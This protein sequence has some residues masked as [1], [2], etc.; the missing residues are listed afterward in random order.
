MIHARR[1][2]EAR[3][4]EAHGGGCDNSGA[5]GHLEAT[6][7]ALMNYL[8]LNGPGPRRGKD[9]VW[10]RLV[11]ERFRPQL[12]GIVEAINE[13]PSQNGNSPRSLAIG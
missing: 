4:E 5:D 1:Q 7:C 9:A 13:A 12:F 3:S 8:D 6:K 10:I 11:I 2:L